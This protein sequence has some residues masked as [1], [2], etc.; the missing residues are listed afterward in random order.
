MLLLDF[1]PLRRLKTGRLVSCVLEKMPFF[2]LAAASGLITFIVQSNSGAMVERLPF[3]ARAS[4]AL[5]SCCRYLGKWVWPVNLS[6]FYPHPGQRPM[7]TVLLC[8]VLLLVISVLAIRFRPQRPY[9]FVGWF[10]FLGTLVPVIGLIQVGIQSLAD[11]YTYLPM[12]GLLFPLVWGA[13]ELTSHWRYRSVL[14]PAMGIAVLLLC[15]AATRKQIEVWKNGETLFRHALEVTRNNTVAHLNLGVVL[16]KQGHLEDAR[17]EYD[18]ALR[19]T[20]ESAEAR[21]NLGIVLEK[22][23]RDDEALG[24]LRE[25]LRLE[26]NS[27]EA[28]NAAGAILGREAHFSQAVDYIEKAIALKP[29]F[30]EAHFNLAVIQA[31]RGNLDAA[32]SQYEETLKLRPSDA[33]AHNFLGGALAK[34]GR[35]DDAISH[36]EKAASIKPDF[37]DAL[38]NL[39]HARELKNSPPAAGPSKP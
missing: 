13:Q 24:Q 28:C 7:T 39:A 35:L 2:A 20:P 22:M 1:W 32:I 38:K 31:T 34:Q 6:V 12:I 27:A 26:P 3:I 4:N 18:Q 25:A 5:V 37:E 23:G 11:R 10:W 30:A 8:G 9:L 16:E 17:A 36:F 15:S 19:L 33:E 14:L 29:E 21:R